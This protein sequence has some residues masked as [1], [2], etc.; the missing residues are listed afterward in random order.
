MTWPTL[1]ACSVTPER[2]ARMSSPLSEK[3]VARKTRRTDLGLTCLTRR[4]TTRRPENAPTPGQI[5]LA[6]PPNGWAMSC[7]QGPPPWWPGAPN[8]QRQTLPRRIGARPLA[9]SCSVG[10]HALL[11]PLPRSEVSRAMEKRDD[12]NQ[13]GM[14]LVEQPVAEHE[15]LP[16]PGI[17]AL[18]DDATTLAQRCERVCSRESSL[19]N[20]EGAGPRILSDELQRLVQGRLSAR[21][22]DYS[23]P[24]RHLRRSS[25]STCSWGI[26]RPSSSSRMPSSISEIT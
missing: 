18:G 11:A 9:G 2:A 7:R 12:T 24:S 19:E 23:A 16:Q 15:D 8:V 1:E 10:P 3:T 5:H 22:P 20:S 4:Q 13:I 21:R 25:C 17:V 6:T 14:H 26:P